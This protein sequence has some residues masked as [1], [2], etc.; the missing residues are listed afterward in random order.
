MRQSVRIMKQCLEK[1]RLP[2][3]QGPVSVPDNKIVPPRREVM[4]LH[5]GAH[6]SF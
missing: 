1:L 5:G 6:P 3:G 4:K 2:E